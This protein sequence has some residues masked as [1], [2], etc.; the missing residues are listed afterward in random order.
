MDQTR[1]QGSMQL[2]LEASDELV[3]S[4]RNDG[5]WYT[6]QTLDARNIQLSVLLSPVEGVHQNEMSRL[7]KPVDDYPNGVKLTASEK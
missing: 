6:M 2:H 3:P 4:V 7:G 5:L 1:P